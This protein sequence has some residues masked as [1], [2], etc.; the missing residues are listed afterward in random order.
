[1][2]S[3]TPNAC[4][5]SSPEAMP[6]RYFRFCAS[7]PCRSTV[8]MVYICAW[9]AAALHGLSWI[10]SSTAHGGGQRQAGAA[11]LLGDQGGEVAG[12]GEG[13]DELGRVGRLV[14]ELHPVLIGKPLADAPHPLADVAPAGVEGQGD[15]HRG[16]A[17]AEAPAWIVTWPV[18]P[19]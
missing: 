15:G 18:G 9:H 1:M 4:S 13:F 5:R 6:G 7:L 3:V 12:L 2:G 14:V 11:V 8:P 16:I 10:V 19:R 17:H